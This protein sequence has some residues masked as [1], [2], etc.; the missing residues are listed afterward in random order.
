MHGITNECTHVGT[1]TTI[2]D[3]KTAHKHSSLASFQ[4]YDTTQ[5]SVQLQRGFAHWG[6]DPWPSG[7]LPLDPAG[8][9]VPRPRYRLAL[10]ARNLPPISTSWFAP[11]FNQWKASKQNAIDSRA[12]QLS[13]TTSPS[14]E[15]FYY[16]INQA[17]NTLD[18]FTARHI[19]KV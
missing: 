17:W 3:H 19:S 5:K 9:T 1:A 15:W 11:G 18:Y 2:N 8:G 16:E 7:T 12:R 10:R 6:P 4:A 13:I 14:C